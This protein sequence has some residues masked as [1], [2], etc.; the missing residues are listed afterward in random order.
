MS[1]LE[2]KKPKDDKMY[3]VNGTKFESFTKAV[4]Y[5]DSIKAEVFGVREN[6]RV[7]TPAAPASSKKMKMYR[8]RMAAYKAQE[9]GKVSA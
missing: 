2:T 5:A 1:G 4:A 9:A 3:E 6:R 7:W 8:E